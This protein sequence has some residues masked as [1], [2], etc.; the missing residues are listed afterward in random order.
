MSTLLIAS[1]DTTSTT[2]SFALYLLANDPAIQ[3]ACSKEVKLLLTDSGND[4][5]SSPDDLVYCTALVK[6]S[7]RIYPP[8]AVVGRTLTKPVTLS[9]G[10]VLPKGAHPVIPIFAIHRHEKI[11]PRPLECHPERWCQRDENDTCWVARHYQEEQPKGQPKES[12]S[13]PCIA[14]GN[15]DALIA[16]SVGGRNCPGAK[17]AFQEAVIV[18]A[19]LVQH[20][21]F[22]TVPGYTVRLNLNG[23]LP[24]PVDGVPLRIEKRE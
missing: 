12:S 8:A 19:N 4:K 14:A 16:F 10:F 5:I 20:F 7:L 23:P 6:E 3:A 17:F 18:I 24:Y 22:S 9:D 15:P 2:L 1:Y 13:Q 21:K 11:F